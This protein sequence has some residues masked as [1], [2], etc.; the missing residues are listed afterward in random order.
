MSQK[1]HATL[2]GISPHSILHANQ[3]EE[4]E[5]KKEEN[6]QVLIKQVQL[7]SALSTQTQMRIHMDP[8]PW[9]YFRSHNPPNV[10]LPSTSNHTQMY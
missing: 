9:L 1:T 8:S 3:N 4:K 10:T 2:K 6:R 5:D 7:H